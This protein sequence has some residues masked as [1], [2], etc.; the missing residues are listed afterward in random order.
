MQCPR[1]IMDSV[2]GFY[3]VVWGFESL[4]V[5]HLKENEMKKQK[6]IKEY[7][8]CN[9]GNLYDMEG[10]LDDIIKKLQDK[11][12]YYENQGYFELELEHEVEC[13]PYDSNEYYELFIHGKRY[14]T[15]SERKKRL[16]DAKRQREKKK[17][18]EKKKEENE[19]KLYEQLKE[20]YE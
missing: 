16:S 4:S 5:Y 14:E 17:L 11:K 3:P 1:N 6:I 2:T 13:L 15:E 19:R 8:I 12:E 10:Q 7:K 18:N 9:M 20:K